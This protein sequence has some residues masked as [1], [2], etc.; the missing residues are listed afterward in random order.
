[1]IGKAG[2]RDTLSVGRT[3]EVAKNPCPKTRA[4]KH[5]ARREAGR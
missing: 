5:N 2:D 3:A 1:M 4:Y